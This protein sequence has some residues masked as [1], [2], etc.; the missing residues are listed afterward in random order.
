MSLELCQIFVDSGHIGDPNYHA[1]STDAQR[2]PDEPGVLRMIY[3]TM[4]RPTLYSGTVGKGG[5][6]TWILHAQSR[7]PR[8]T[9][10][11]EMAARRYA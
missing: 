9:R 3:R 2:Q 11:A 4:V 7:L 1:R 5:H 8:L 6:F 10:Y